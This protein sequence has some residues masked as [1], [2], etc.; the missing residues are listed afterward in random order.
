MKPNNPKNN[1]AL[2]VVYH[3]HFQ[4]LSLFI[5]SSYHDSYSS[6]ITASF[7]DILF[8]HVLFRNSLQTLW[9]YTATAERYFQII[10]QQ[11][12]EAQSIKRHKNEHG[13]N[14]E[15]TRELHS[16]EAH[17]TSSATDRI[18][19][20]LVF[21][22]QNF[23][24]EAIASKLRLSSSSVNPISCLCSESETLRFQKMK[25]ARLLHS[26]GSEQLLSNNRQLTL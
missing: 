18:K 5:F 24:V 11:E 21:T 2:T 23:P 13:Q 4:L 6:A 10:E 1:K 20:W 17:L 8:Y 25:I 16:S 12:Q 22:N 7:L 19:R 14:I 3:K 9:R 15:V 26:N